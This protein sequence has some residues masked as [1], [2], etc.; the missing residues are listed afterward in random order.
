MLF[1]RLVAW[2]VVCA[3]I[4]I[5]RLRVLFLQRLR[6]LLLDRGQ[7]RIVYWQVG[8]RTRGRARLPPLFRRVVHRSACFG[9]SRVLSILVS[10][11][12]QRGSYWF[13]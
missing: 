7:L 11:L 10:R 3:A 9:F 12:L 6:V 8:G 4:G 2:L 13:Y 1:E 5:R